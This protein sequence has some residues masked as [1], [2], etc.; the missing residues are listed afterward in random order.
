MKYQPSLLL[1]PAVADTG[2]TSGV[3]TAPTPD[4]G[5]V[6]D[7]AMAEAFS[8][9]FESLDSKVKSKPEEA[10]A[11][12]EK[13]LEPK[14]DAKK[15]VKT[16]EAKK[17]DKA[18]APQ[19]K[20][21]E[22]AGLKQHSEQLLKELKEERAAKAQLQK[23]YE[24][25]K[26]AGENLSKVTQEIAASKKEIERLRGELGAAKFT[27]SDSF[28]S[29][30]QVPWDRAVKRIA[31]QVEQLQ[32][33]V[34]KDENDQPKYRPAQWK[35]FSE[36][37]QLPTGE[38]LSKIRAAFGENA[39]VVN[40]FYFDLQQ[41]ATAYQDA[42][43]D[44]RSQWQSKQQQAETAKI[45]EQTAIGEMWEK[46]NG[47]IATKHPDWFGEKPDDPE[48]NTLMKEGYKLV[49]SAYGNNNLSPQQKV[50]LDANIRHR[51]SV[52]QAREYLITKLTA[53]NSEL[54]EKLSGKKASSP[55]SSQRI[56]DTTTQQPDKGV[57]EGLD[58]SLFE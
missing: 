49:D 22:P 14:P 19:P 20:K 9:P 40:Q 38:A 1:D 8:D 3:D 51:A 26:A 39:P 2:T 41:R 50:L 21:G 13:E 47:D 30:H 33:I 54:E 48:Y 29:T 36:I 28:K 23:E 7:P 10:P 46:V 32:V 34:G 35:D 44:E 56:G 42:Q 5:P 18:A 57:V 27:L 12:E 31:S 11:L 24:A 43:E 4:L 58:S 6:H 37:Y 53:R 25:S 52:F 55:G 16:P 15:E 45:Q 17:D